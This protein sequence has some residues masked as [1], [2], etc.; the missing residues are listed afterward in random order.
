MHKEQLYLNAAFESLTCQT[1]KSIYYFTNYTNQYIQFQE[2]I[3]PDRKLQYKYTETTQTKFFRHKK[4]SQVLQNIQK[5]FLQRVKQY[6]DQQHFKRYGISFM[7]MRY[8]IQKSN[9]YLFG[10]KIG[11][12]KEENMICL[13]KEEVCKPQKLETWAIGN[14]FLKQLLLIRAISNWK[15]RVIV[16]GMI[17]LRRGREFLHSVLLQFFWLNQL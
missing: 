7:K 16:Y 8:Y 14:S 17:L 12:L 4:T 15:Q 9:Y 3:P 13:L 5:Y 6:F 11:E 10:D 2:T 1:F